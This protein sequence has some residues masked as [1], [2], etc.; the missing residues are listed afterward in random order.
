VKLTH[1]QKE[2]RLSNENKLLKEI[3]Q[4]YEVVLEEWSDTHNLTLTEET[5][6]ALTDLESR[7]MKLNQYGDL[8]L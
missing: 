5:R 8:S 4:T 6:I 3:V 1:E 7:W 2:E